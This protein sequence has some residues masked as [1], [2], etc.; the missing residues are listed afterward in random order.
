MRAIDVSHRSLG[1]FSQT[2]FPVESTQ[3]CCR[4]KSLVF[5]DSA[6]FNAREFFQTAYPQGNSNPCPRLERAVS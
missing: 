5:S 2:S 1:S 4:K 3:R 6:W